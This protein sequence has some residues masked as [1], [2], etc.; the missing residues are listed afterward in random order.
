LASAASPVFAGRRSRVERRLTQ[1]VIASGAL[2]TTPDMAYATNWNIAK[3][4]GHK[5]GRAHGTYDQVAALEWLVS[6]NI[7]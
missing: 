7:I 4:S 2:T 6:E 1:V 3:M 5:V